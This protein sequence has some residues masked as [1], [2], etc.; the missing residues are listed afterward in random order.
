MRCGVG[1][2]LLQL[3]HGSAGLQRWRRHGS[4][5]TSAWRSFFAA[6]ALP[7]LVQ[8]GACFNAVAYPQF[9]DGARSFVSSVVANVGCC[10][11]MA[12]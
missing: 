4:P 8:C 3:L 11:L 7:Q 5:S 1:P 2:C 9:A 6:V 12:P 10:V